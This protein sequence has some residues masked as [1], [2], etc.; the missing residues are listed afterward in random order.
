M[1]SISDFKSNLP[2]TIFGRKSETFLFPTSFSVGETSNV[3]QKIYDKFQEE[4]KVSFYYDV[5]FIGSYLSS[6]IRFG[7]SFTDT[8]P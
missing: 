2:K 6:S 3:T 8:F 4:K 5:T 1:V 7:S